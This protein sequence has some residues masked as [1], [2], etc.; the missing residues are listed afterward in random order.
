MIAGL[1]AGF[2]AGVI[3]GGIIVFILLRKN[4]S[5]LEAKIAEN[6]QQLHAALEAK[7]S[8]EAAV[9][10]ALKSEEEL[11][12][13]RKENSRLQVELAAMIKEKEAA[14]EKIEWSEKAQTQLKNAFEALS[15]ATLRNNADGF[16][17][18]ARAELENLLNQIRGDWGV[19]K[20]E[21][22]KMVEPLSET[23]GKMDS[24][25]REIEQK[26]EGAYQGLQQELKHLYSAQDQLR[27]LTLQLNQAL[28]STEVRGQWGQMQLRRVVELA[29]MEPHVD[30]SEQVTVESGRPDL[31]V[32]LPNGG[33]L[34]V[35]AKAP[36]KNYFDAMQAPQEKREE[37][38]AAF[39]RDVRSVV[40][41]LAGKKYWTQ[42][43]ATPE[44]VVMFV[45]NEASIGAACEY[46][47]SLI[48]FAATNR[49]LIAT[50]MTLLAL[51]RAVAFGWQQ[52]R[53]TEHARQIA[54]MGKELY[55]RIATFVGHI[56]DAGNGLTK[57]VRDYNQ[58]VA[59][60]ESRLMPAARKLRE[61]GIADKEIQL[62]EQVDLAPRLPVVEKNKDAQDGE[63]S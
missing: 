17:K 38:L 14:A 12:Q 7:A 50:P 40:Q 21:L 57:A 41:N 49:V 55:E 34:P 24:A 27:V 37:L 18:Q 53:V 56:A 3:A 61:A 19:H 32:Y 8:A 58:A 42:F 30:F 1:A 10:H 5:Y 2:F 9:Q 25:I 36:M 45:P 6:Q 46:D 26:R 39:A 33:V 43:P 20:T 59:S 51:L 44:V 31:I 48:E 28:R 13:A 11:A 22:Q 16:L 47:G 35:D 60:L 63:P 52:H 4:A 62:P 54:S 23:L 15:A 29:G